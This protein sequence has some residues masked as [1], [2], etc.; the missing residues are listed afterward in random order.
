MTFAIKCGQ[1]KCDASTVELICS[2]FHAFFKRYFKGFPCL[3]Q[4]ND[5]QRNAQKS[6]SLCGFE[7]ARFLVSRS[8]K[9]EW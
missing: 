3:K 6:V 2:K 5:G 4:K 1:F 7:I 8:R 9:F